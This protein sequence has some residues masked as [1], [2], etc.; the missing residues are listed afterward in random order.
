MRAL[1]ALLFVVLVSSSAACGGIID[2]SENQV[3]PFSG[4]LEDDGGAVHNFSVGRNGEFSV[5]LTALSPDPDRFVGLSFGDV[6]NG[7]CSPSLFY[8]NNFAVLNRTALSGRISR[9]NFCIYIFDSGALE[10][11][12]TYTVEVSYP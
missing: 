7:Q 10:R 8:V 4:T 12:Q 1:S 5:R 6:I 11:D 9:G 3:Q 2:P